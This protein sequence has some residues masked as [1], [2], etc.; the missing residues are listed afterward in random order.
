MFNHLGH[1]DFTDNVKPVDTVTKGEQSEIEDG[2]IV[3]QD[4]DST[5]ETEEVRSRK[6][7]VPSP[8]R[9]SHFSSK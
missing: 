7:Q 5:G 9:G 4:I 8:H 2:E 1:F 6:H 3:E